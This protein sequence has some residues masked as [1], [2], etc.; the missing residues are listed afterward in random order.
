[1][2]SVPFHG[3]GMYCTKPGSGFRFDVTIGFEDFRIVD[4]HIDLSDSDPF[5]GVLNDKGILLEFEGLD[6]GGQEAEVTEK[7]VDAYYPIADGTIPWVLFDNLEKFLQ[8]KFAEMP[9]S[10]IIRSKEKIQ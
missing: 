3:S 6:A 1:M 4:D 9:V 8:E 10:E 5:L 2:S 7:L